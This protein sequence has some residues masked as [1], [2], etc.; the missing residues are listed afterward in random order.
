MRNDSDK[1]HY[2]KENVEAFIEEV[3]APA[4]TAPSSDAEAAR[5]REE[6]AREEQE[7]A[8]REL[9]AVGFDVE[10]LDKLAAERSEKRKKLAEETRRRAVDASAEVGRHLADIAPLIFYRSNRLTRSST[11]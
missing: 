11:R 9:Q 5:A 2:G 4:R 10:R 6:L 7:L 3:V 1:K 8:R